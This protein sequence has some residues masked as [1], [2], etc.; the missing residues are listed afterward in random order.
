MGAIML[1][2]PRSL[3][4]MVAGIVRESELPVTVKIRTGAE[5]VCVGRLQVCMQACACW[6]VH[7]SVHVYMR[8][9]TILPVFIQ[10]FLRCMLVPSE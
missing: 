1:R 6:C 9:C 2:K 4:K 5:K 7:A 8:T 3:A 10:L